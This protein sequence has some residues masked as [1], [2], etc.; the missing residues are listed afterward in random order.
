MKL[1]VGGDP[2]I[3]LRDKK[4][5]QFVSVTDFDVPGTK[6]K[7]HPVKKGAIQKDGTALEINI[8]PAD[9]AKDFKDNLATVIQEARSY[10]PE[11]IEFVFTPVVDYAKDYYTRIPTL[12]LELGCDPDYNGQTGERNNN[13][14]PIG[15]MRTAS[16]HITLGWGEGFD[17]MDATHFWDCRQ[18]STRLNTYFS[19][20]KPLWDKDQRRHQVYGAGAAFRPKPFGVEF[21]S[22]SNAWVGKPVLHE[23]IF[24]SVKWVFNHAL[25]G[26]KINNMAYYSFNA[27]DQQE[28]KRQ[29]VADYFQDASFPAFPKEAIEAPARKAF[30]G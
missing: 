23:W 20:F 11:N 9:N 2:E 6:A 21:R 10:V 29:F 19:Q 16:G 8:D 1:L 3:F 15:T 18:M 22:L 27:P 25:T 5:K 12:A 4:T 30:N 26:G 28:V 14:V 7:P 17:P 13:P 24:D